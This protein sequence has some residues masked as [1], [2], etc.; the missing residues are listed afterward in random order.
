MLLTAPPPTPQTSPHA[1]KGKAGLGYKL[2][3]FV[4]IK[5]TDMPRPEIESSLCRLLSQILV[6]LI[7]IA[8][9]REAGFARVLP[10]T[11]RC[12]PGRAS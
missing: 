12:K 10:L 5:L 3:I 9:S 2:K 4:L 11:N 6:V 7:A 1:P 8:R